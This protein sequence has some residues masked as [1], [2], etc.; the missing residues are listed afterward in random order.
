MASFL[1]EHY[2]MAHSNTKRVESLLH[3]LPTQES[4]P[5]LTS[6][7][8][9]YSLILNI[10]SLSLEQNY[11]KHTVEI[12]INTRNII[13]KHILLSC[14]FDDFSHP[15]YHHLSPLILL[16][17]TRNHQWAVTNI[18]ITVT[19]RS[20]NITRTWWWYCVNNTLVSSVP[21][22]PVDVLIIFP[23]GQVAV[24]IVVVRP[25]RRHRRYAP[26]H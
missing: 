1:H 23:Q 10:Y 17:T 9:L 18:C 4:T 25:R 16:L 2:I 15:H 11:L 13:N 19:D 22:P 7:T 20:R 12:P 3:D 21:P 5:S 14:S 8:V 6:S 24:V 26:H